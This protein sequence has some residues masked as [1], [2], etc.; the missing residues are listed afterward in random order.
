ML[1]DTT[2]EIKWNKKYKFKKPMNE[3][4]MLLSV[5]ILI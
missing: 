1:I 4:T 5:V 2:R 3:Q